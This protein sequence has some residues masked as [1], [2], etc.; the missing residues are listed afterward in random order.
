[1][2]GCV[3]PPGFD[4][5][6]AKET[7]NRWIAHETA[8]ATREVTEAIEA[9]R[10]NDAADAIYRFVWNV[11]C[12]W[13]LELAKPVL[14]GEDGAAKTETRAM[15]A[16]ARDEILK[17]LHP[18][19]PFITEELWAVTAKRDGL[20]ALAPWSRKA[21]ELDAGATGLDVDHKPERSARFR[22]SCLRSMPPI[23]ATPPP[24]PRSAGWS[25]SSPR[26]ARCARK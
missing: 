15:V 12:D 23:S 26:S 1:M 24:K 6:K 3:L 20:L 16:W 19:M 4:P 9:Y 25:I 13:Y 14:L 17:L 10:F 8:R 21:G 22:R 7:L 18:F 5:T 11:Y 2:N